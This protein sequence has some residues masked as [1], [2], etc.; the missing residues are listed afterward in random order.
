MLTDEEQTAFAMLSAGSGYPVWMHEGT[1]RG[2][3]AVFLSW[4]VYSP[5][6]K[7]F[8]SVA[9]PWAMFLHASD[10]R[11]CTWSRVKGL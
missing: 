2:K 10:L 7:K 5:R 4:L 9:K 8:I 11:D 3:R 6:K 1:F